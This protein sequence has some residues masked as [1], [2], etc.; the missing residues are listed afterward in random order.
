MLSKALLFLVDVVFSLLVYGLLLRLLMQQ[1]RAPFHNPLGQAVLAVSDWI[2]KPLRRVVPGWRGFDGS[3]FLAAWF[4]Q[5]MWQLVEIVVLR[6]WAT[7][8]AWAGPLVLMAL[9]GLLKATLYLFMIVLIVQAVL[10]WT[11]PHGPLAGLLNAL[12]FPVLAPIRRRIPA[13][14]GTL[15]LSPL[16]AIVAIQLLLIVPVAWLEQAIAGLFQ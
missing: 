5:W 2:V 8:F 4:L 14:G 12:T 13:L 7:A 16:I 9:V 3:T 6:D 1:F 11:A 15:D 10:S